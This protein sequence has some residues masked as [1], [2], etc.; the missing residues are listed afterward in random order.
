MLLHKDACFLPCGKHFFEISQFVLIYCLYQPG[1]FWVILRGLSN[2][3]MHKLEAEGTQEAADNSGLTC[4]SHKLTINMDGPL[5][6]LRGRDG[7]R[8][9]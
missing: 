8:D 9:G 3:K 6:S 1:V 5:Y 2:H 7:K 4:L